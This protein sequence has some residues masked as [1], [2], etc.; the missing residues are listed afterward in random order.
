[1]TA[2]VHIPALRRFLHL[3]CGLLL[4]VGSMGCS[5][6]RIYVVRHA[7]RANDT[8][9]TSLSPAGLA[10]AD[11]L[12]ERLAD[13]SIDGIY[14]TPYLRTQQTAQPLAKRRK[15]PLTEY[16]VRPTQT[17]VD[18]LRLMR[19]RN[20][21]VVGHSNTILEIARGLGTTPTRQTIEHGDYDNLLVIT[22][23][24]WLFGRQQSLQELTYGRPTAP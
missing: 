12:A 23:R 18:Q 2:P 13:A 6:T 5:A 17:L 24:R 15:L 9:T 11:A 10:R 4:L 22:S 16:P 21:L 7:E 14:V 20:V 19:G 8:D 3:C 1:M